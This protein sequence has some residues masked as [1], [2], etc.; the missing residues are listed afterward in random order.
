MKAPSEQSTKRPVSRIR[1]IPGMKSRETKGLYQDP[2]FDTALGK[3]NMR[4]A[5]KNYKFLDEYRE[6]E[7]GSLRDQLKDTKDDYDRETIAKAIQSQKSRL[8]TLKRRDEDEEILSKLK[9]KKMSRAKKREF[10]L[11]ERFSKMNS[12]EVART[13]EKRRRKV[14]QKQKKLL[15]ERRPQSD[16]TE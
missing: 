15:P 14:A 7:L 11:K 6:S 10:V 16:Q 12:R 1:D 4:Q 13:V 2:R 3:A 5:R 8:E 9:H